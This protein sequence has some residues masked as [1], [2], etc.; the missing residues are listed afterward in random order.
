MRTGFRFVFTFKLAGIVLIALLALSACGGEK[1]PPDDVTADATAVDFVS[2]T[3]LVETMPALEPVELAPDEKLRVVATTNIIAD[4]VA[5]VGDDHIDLTALLPV[6]ADPHSFEATPSD[7]RAL[8]GAHV[9]FFDHAHLYAPHLWNAKEVM[10][11]GLQFQHSG[12]A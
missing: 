7:Y 10:G 1:S 6:G 4:V 11:V 2:E 9:L 3:T 5:N 8:E 12:A